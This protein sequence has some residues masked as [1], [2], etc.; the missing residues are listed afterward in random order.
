MS[1]SNKKE[2]LDG[3]KS[4]FNPADRQASKSA[5]RE[6]EKKILFSDGVKALFLFCPKKEEKIQPHKLIKVDLPK[7]KNHV[8]D[9]LKK[10]ISKT[11]AIL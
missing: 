1:R 3:L 4:S 11:K 10:G 9:Y 7:K 6:R 5:A 2:K 8:H